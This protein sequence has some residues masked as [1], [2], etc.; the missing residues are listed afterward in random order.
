MDRVMNKPQGS[1]GDPVLGGRL[2][3]IREA[4]GLSLRDVELRSGGEI[5]P[6]TLS[7]YERGNREL[8]VSRLMRLAEIYNVAITDL[9]R[10]QVIDVR[11]TAEPDD[12]E[13]HHSHH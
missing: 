8:S 3:A 2:R 7:A 6:S 1:T 11:D 12:R 9:L 4:Y 10:P 13:R 5:R